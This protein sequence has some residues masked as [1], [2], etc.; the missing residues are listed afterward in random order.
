[1]AVPRGRWQPEQRQLGATGAWAMPM[2]GS[3]LGGNAL[4]AGVSGR[5][6]AAAQLERAT[7]SF[8]QHPWLVSVL[9]PIDERG[10]ALRFEIVLRTIISPLASTS[11][12]VAADRVDSHLA[13]LSSPESSMASRGCT[14]EASR[15]SEMTLN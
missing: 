13:H 12:P 4:G 9:L 8:I 6:L 7:P 3:V 1:M 11:H 14:P 10:F 5:A 2:R 15:T